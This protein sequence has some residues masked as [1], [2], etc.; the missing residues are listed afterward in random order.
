MAKSVWL[1]IML[2][3]AGGAFYVYDGMEYNSWMKNLPLMIVDVL[4]VIAL[5]W[6]LRKK[7]NLKKERNH[8]Q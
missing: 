1:P 3:L 2:L 7:E 4:I 5:F 8:K 6:A